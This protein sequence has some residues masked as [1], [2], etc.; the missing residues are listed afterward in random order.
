M[1]PE[2]A[3]KKTQ[4]ELNENVS[5]WKERFENYVTETVKNKES[6]MERRQKFHKWSNLT[7]YSTIGRA[8]ESHLPSNCIRHFYC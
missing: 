5:K 3:I 2:E 1:L 7:V 4:Q 6:I 8:K